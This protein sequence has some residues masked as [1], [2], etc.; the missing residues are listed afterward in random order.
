MMSDDPFGFE[1]AHGEILPPIDPDDIEHHIAYLEA[2]ASELA[3]YTQIERELLDNGFS[4]RDAGINNYFAY[5]ESLPDNFS[6]PTYH[7]LFKAITVLD[8][9]GYE[10]SPVEQMVFVDE[11][12]IAHLE[13][14]FLY[15]D[16]NDRAWLATLRGIFPQAKFLKATDDEM[17]IASFRERSLMR[18][19]IE[20]NLYDFREKAQRII[21]E[22][23][24]D[25]LEDDVDNSLL[26]GIL[27]FCVI[28]IYDPKSNETYDSA[29]EL[30]QNALTGIGFTEDEI[31]P[32]LRSIHDRALSDE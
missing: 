20:N 5:S 6:E 14:I 21:Q 17:L 22:S 29:I 13:G 12:L 30:A 15:S 2:D 4:L 24:V 32:F 8:S 27:L 31:L 19:D 3:Y 23:V 1:N 28:A 10:D 25:M 16:D 11:E 7:R 26:E 9:L 18:L